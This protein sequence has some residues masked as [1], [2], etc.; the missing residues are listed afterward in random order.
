MSSVMKVIFGEAYL[1]R[2]QPTREFSHSEETV[3]PQQ[4]ANSV[5]PHP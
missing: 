5:G 3:D 4:R 1:W 2:P